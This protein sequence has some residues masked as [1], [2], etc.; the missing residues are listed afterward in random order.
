MMGGGGRNDVA[1]NTVSGDVR[2]ASAVV[3]LCLPLLQTGAK[4]GETMNS[5]VGK[6]MFSEMEGESV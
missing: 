6:L 1:L 4:R 5:K 2:Q 3:S